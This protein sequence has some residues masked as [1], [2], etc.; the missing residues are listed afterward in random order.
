FSLAEVRV[1]YELA[2]RE[3]PTASDIATAL[4][5]DEGYLSRLL[6][7]FRQRGLV[8][9]RAAMHDGR[10]RWLALTSKGRKAF[11]T[12]SARATDSVVGLIQHLS[13]PEQQQLVSAVT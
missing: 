1:L 6:R 10:Q 4:G 8:R 12:L 2:H 11:E 13:P 3:Q 5:M 7:R 9:A